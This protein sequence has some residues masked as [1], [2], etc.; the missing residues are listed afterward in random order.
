MARYK[1]YSYA[2]GKFIPVHFASQILPGTFEYTLNHLID[3][4]LDLSLFDERFRNDETG[5]T[6]YDPRILL[7]IVLYA[8]SR[9]IVSSR[10]IEQ[11]CRENV[12]FMALSADTRPHFTTIADFISSMDKEIIHLFRDVLLVCDDLGLIGKEMFAIDGCKMPSNASKEWSGTRADFEKKAAKLGK[13]I[14]H[15]IKTHREQDQQQTDQNIAAR[16]AQYVE[17][18]RN[19]ARKIREWLKDHDDKP[20]KTGKPKKSNITDNESAKMKTS[21]GVIQGYDGV[22][23]VDGKHQVIVHAEAFGEAQ[24]HDLLKPMVE[25][26]R[27]NFQAMGRDEDVFKRAKLS[28]DSGFHTEENMKMLFAGEIDAYVADNRFRKRDPRF[29][30]ADRYRERHR[31]ERAKLTGRKGLFSTTDF[32]FPEDLSHCICPAGKRLYRSGHNVAVRNFLATK[33]KGAKSCCLPCHLRSQC[34]RHPERT[35]TRQVAY[36]HGRSARGKETYTERM[37]HKIDSTVGRVLYS[38]RVAIAEP[39]FAHICRVMGL[40]RFTLRGKKKVNVQWNLFCIV[41]NLKKVARY[42]PGFV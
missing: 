25:G 5:A 29:V 17:T 8:Y 14:G 11:A 20:G 13:A 26:T 28:A 9:G 23:T 40:D 24:E 18:L 15:I 41:H 34:L 32:I 33:F 31:Q 12:V 39:P 4:E 21:H 30:D 27:Q 6:A 2:Q 37:K 3:H 19:R 38:M 1:P 36:F 10:K 22:T 42:G 7:K 35:E 16:E